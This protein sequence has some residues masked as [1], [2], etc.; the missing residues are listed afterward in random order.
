MPLNDR[1]F[2]SIYEIVDKSFRNATGT[3]LMSKVTK[4]DVTNKL[5]WVPELGDQP[6]PLVGFDYEVKYYDTDNAGIINEK[7]AKVSPMVP[8]IGDLVFIALERGTQRLPRCIGKVYSQN[9]IL[10]SLDDA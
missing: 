3:L 10:S 6:V 8:E 2:Q 4:R 5:V 9:Y 1:D 7:K